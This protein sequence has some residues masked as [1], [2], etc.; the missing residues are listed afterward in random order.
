MFENLP[1]GKEI[2]GS[3]ALL[4][5]FSPPAGLAE[6]FAPRYAVYG[7]SLVYWVDLLSLL[8]LQV[9]IA[10]VF[11]LVIYRVIIRPQDFESLKT[12][13]LVYG[14]IVPFWLVMP[15]YFLRIIGIRNLLMRFA[16]GCLV[17]IVSMFRATEGELGLELGKSCISI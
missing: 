15:V 16:T 1:H 6:Y 7:F 10:S 12:M 4:F 17:P 9:I 5:E 13:M 3:Q 14:I 11:G 8:L 2:P